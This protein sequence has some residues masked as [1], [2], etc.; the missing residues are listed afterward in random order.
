MGCSMFLD[1]LLQRFVKMVTEHSNAQLGERIWLQTCRRI[2]EIQL[3][4]YYAAP[5]DKRNDIELNPHEIIKGAIENC[6]PLMLLQKVKVVQ[7]LTMFQFLLASP[8]HTLKLSDGST[9][10]V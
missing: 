5:E 7:S 10:Q 8:G 9:R 3:A 2:K 6:R 1:P 4:K